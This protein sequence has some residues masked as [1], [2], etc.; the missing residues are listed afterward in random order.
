MKEESRIVQRDIQSTI[1]HELN[2][3]LIRNLN[4]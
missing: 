3:S 4:A 1:S 2:A